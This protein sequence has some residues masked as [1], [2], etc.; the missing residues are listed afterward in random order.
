MFYHMFLNVGKE[1]ATICGL[2]DSR[3]SQRDVS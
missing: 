2:G 1:A 3:L